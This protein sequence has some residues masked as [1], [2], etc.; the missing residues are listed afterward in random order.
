MDAIF[1]TLTAQKTSCKNTNLRLM[2]CWAQ[3]GCW[4]T[5][6]AVL[7]LPD[8]TLL[9]DERILW[10][11]RFKWK[12]QSAVPSWPNGI[13]V[14]SRQ[15]RV[16]SFPNAVSFQFSNQSRFFAK[17][18]PFSPTHPVS[19]SHRMGLLLF[20]KE[21]PCSFSLFLFLESRYQGDFPLQPTYT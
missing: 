6:V 3:W 10:S 19:H 5:E 11:S 7:Q 14:V 20:D 1:F 17:F 9:R 18:S 15:S 21:T 13:V 12:S 2:R 8:E 4:D 16:T